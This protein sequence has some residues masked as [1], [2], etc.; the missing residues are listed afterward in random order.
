MW[1]EPSGLNYVVVTRH[2]F[3][4]FQENLAM[5]NTFTSIPLASEMLFH[6]S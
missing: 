6:P 1:Q 3:V 4:I 5:H 2:N